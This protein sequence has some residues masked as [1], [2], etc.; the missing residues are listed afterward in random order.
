MSRQEG[1]AAQA[2]HGGEE[3]GKP[4]V[5][6]SEALDLLSLAPVLIRQVLDECHPAKHLNKERNSTVRHKSPDI[7]PKLT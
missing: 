7:S 2:D 3:Q 5:P 1:R 6:V 4:A